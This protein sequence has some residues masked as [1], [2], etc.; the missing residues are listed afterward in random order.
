MDDCRFTKEP[1]DLRAIN[2]HRQ[3]QNP[4]TPAVYKI[5]SGPRKQ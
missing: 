2:D 3:Q 5:R 1:S 4:A